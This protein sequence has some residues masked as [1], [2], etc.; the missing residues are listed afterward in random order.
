MN[1]IGILP[2]RARRK[3]VKMCEGKIMRMP[4]IK[5]QKGPHPDTIYWSLYA[6]CPVAFETD[7]GS[8]K[9]DIHSMARWNHHELY[10]EGRREDDKSGFEAW[11]VFE[12]HHANYGTGC[13]QRTD[14]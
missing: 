4:L 12:Q 3:V 9:L 5:I 8:L 10:L 1:L 13:I 14:W 7:Q 6:R 2:F 11:Y